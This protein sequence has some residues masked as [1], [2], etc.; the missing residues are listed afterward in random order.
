LK[1]TEISIPGPKLII[2]TVFG[3]HRGY[4]FESYRE[5][6]FKDYGLP[7]KYKQ[8]NES[9]SNK[10]ILRGLH[11]QAPPFAQGKL[12]RVIT[13][14]VLDVIVDIRKG[15]ST[16]GRSFSVE[17]NSENKLILWI[18][19]GFAHG[20]HTL[21]DHT[22]FSYKCTEMYNAESENGLSWNDEQLQ[23]DWGTTNPI[24]SDKDKKY[25]PFNKLNSPFL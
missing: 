4:F 23:I 12:V 18:P 2:P 6:I 3:D 21:E 17:L 15:S 9:K 10:G 25:Q 20:F 22:I 7:T 8:D 14:G 16:Y 1:I 24:L 11:Y 19:E 5:D 13:G